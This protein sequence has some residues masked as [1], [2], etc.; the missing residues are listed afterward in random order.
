MGKEPERL[1][2]FL[3][4]FQQLVGPT[5]HIETRV[6]DKEAISVYLLDMIVKELV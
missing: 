3:Q 1:R 5:K 2:S 4:A 6:I